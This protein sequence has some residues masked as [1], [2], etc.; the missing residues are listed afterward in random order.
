[1]RSQQA[2]D[3]FSLARGLVLSARRRGLASE[4]VPAAI[5]HA[6]QHLLADQPQLRECLITLLRHPA[7]VTLLASDQDGARAQALKEL[8]DGAG[9][10]LPA[11]SV[12]PQQA[13]LDGL[14]EGWQEGGDSAPASGLSADR[15]E[16]DLRSWLLGLGVGVAI[17]AGLSWL[18]LTAFRVAAPPLPAIDPA[19][20]PAGSPATGTAGS[21]LRA[22]ATPVAVD[23]LDRCARLGSPQQETQ[24]LA[25]A[26]NFGKRQT[27]DASGAAIP[28]EPALIVLHETVLDLPSTVELFQRDQA[29]D[30]AQG[31]YHVLIGRDGERVRIVPDQ[32][33]AYGAGDSAFGD[34]SFKTSANNPPSINN[35]AL[36]V[37]LESPEDGRGDQGGHSGYTEA[38]YRAL[39]EQILRW[40][41][42]YGIPLE[43]ITT[44]AAV[45]RSRSRYDP[46]SFRW[47]RFEQVYTQV[48][49]SCA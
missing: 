35:I 40:Q 25:A 3:L 37:S 17:G 28:A 26:S 30:S 29:N 5:A 9:R 6:L 12:S 47:D 8:L 43:R 34:L 48:R 33:R 41:A 23:G 32:A 11:D 19:L 1:M 2:S 16:P 39:A 27:Q 14:L 49:R 15:Q 22:P 42:L 38:Q 20:A 10:S 44:H 21:S 24:R 13:F 45:D 4:E 18:G 36:H 31:S 7:C 46:R